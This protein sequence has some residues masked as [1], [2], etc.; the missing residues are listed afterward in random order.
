LIALLYVAE[1]DYGFHST[2]DLATFEKGQFTPLFDAMMARMQN[3]GDMMATPEAMMATEGSM[4][5]G[6]MMATPEAMMATEDAMMQPMV[7]L[8]PGNISGED[9]ACSAL[10]AELDA[11]LLTALNNHDMMMTSGQ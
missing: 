8:T 9:S 5:S 3:S 1:N 11:Y 6:D 10:R 2:M 4:Q 7:T